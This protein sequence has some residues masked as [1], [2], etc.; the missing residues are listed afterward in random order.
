MQKNEIIRQ[1]VKQTGIETRDVELIVEAT[2]KAIRDNVIAGNRVDFRGF[3]SF[4]PKVQ[5]AR[6][7]R[8]PVNGS[9]SGLRI[10][11]LLILPET[12]KPVFKPSKQYFKIQLKEKN[13]CTT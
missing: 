4:Y 8:R 12:V 7:A 13:P 11:E 10:S 2:I 1:V 5:K 3:G 6:K 9:G